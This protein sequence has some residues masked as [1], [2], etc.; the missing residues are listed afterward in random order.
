MKSIILSAIFSFFI[1]NFFAQKTINCASPFGM[2]TKTRDSIKSERNIISIN[3]VD[4]FYFHRDTSITLRLIIITRSTYPKTELP[5]DNLYRLKARWAG[6]D[7]SLLYGNGRWEK[8]FNWN[9]DHF[10]YAH[11]FSIYSFL[12][13]EK[14]KN[15]KSGFLKKRKKSFNT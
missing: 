13:C 12:P 7:I 9:V 3:L 8:T 14:L 15:L 4:T 6:N 2:W 10:E 1:N 11:D 5:A